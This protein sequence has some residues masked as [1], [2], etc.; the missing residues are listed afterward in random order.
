MKNSGI[1]N[2]GVVAG[3]N[4]NV[5]DNSRGKRNMNINH[6]TGS[7]IQQDGAERVVEKQEQQI[8]QMFEAFLA[9]LK[10]FHV[11]IERQD[12]YIRE[13]GDHLKSIVHHSYERNERNMDRVDKMI[14]RVTEMDRRI[15]DRADRVIDILERKL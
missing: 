1:I 3:D 6:V 13:L 15:Q 14:E 11:Y 8:T 7:V 12:D 9:E 10:S 5:S 4:V 2:K